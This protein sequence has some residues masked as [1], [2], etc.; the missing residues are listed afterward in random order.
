MD[1]D[2]DNALAFV[3]R[4]EGGF[5]NKSVRFRRPH[6]ERSDPEGLRGSCNRRSASRRTAIMGR[7]HNKPARRA[8]RRTLSRA[9]VQFARRS[10]SGQDRFL[11]GWLNRLND[12]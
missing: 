6:H 10:T 8:A 1:S 9:I 2:Y 5:A 12:L 4:W 7:R 11:A 3:L